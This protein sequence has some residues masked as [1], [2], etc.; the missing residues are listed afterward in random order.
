M[1][2]QKELGITIEPDETGTTFEENALIKAETICK[3]SGLPTIADDSGLCVDALGGAP[4]VY[5]ARYCGHHGDDEANNDKLLEEMKDVPAEQRGAK[6]V[7]AVCFILPTGQHLTCRGEC[8]GKV[9]FERLAGDY[10]FGYDPLF[11]PAECGVGRTGKRPNAR[12]PQLRPAHPRRKGRHQPPRQCAGPDGEAA[13]GVFGESGLKALPLGEPARK[14]TREPPATLDSAVRATAKGAV[15]PDKESAKRC[16]AARE[17]RASRSRVHA[18][19][20]RLSRMGESLARRM[21]LL[22]NQY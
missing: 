5:S 3:A 18:S 1:V 13:A 22:C 10:G 15:A 11:I 2:S 9:A 6:F 12:G 21:F 14:R 4:G 16:A 17:K 8:P 19:V 7:A 20:T